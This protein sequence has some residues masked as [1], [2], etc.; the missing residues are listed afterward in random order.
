MYTNILKALT[1]SAIKKS[2]ALHL[3]Q[4]FLNVS[5]K[6]GRPSFVLNGCAQDMELGFGFPGTHFRK[7]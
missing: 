6:L 3:T 1:S 4:W 7:Y 5:P 2:V